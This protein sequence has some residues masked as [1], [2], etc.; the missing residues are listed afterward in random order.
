VCQDEGGLGDVCRFINDFVDSLEGLICGDGSIGDGG[1][2]SHDDLSFSVRKSLGNDG[3]GYLLFL[4]V[5]NGGEGFLFVR[6]SDFSIEVV[7]PGEV[8]FGRILLVQGSTIGGAGGASCGGEIPDI[9]RVLGGWLGD[10]GGLLGRLAIQFVGGRS[11]KLL[12]YFL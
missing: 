6:L 11:I 12:A 1:F 5:F 2:N 8:L 4:F 9:L 10:R 3:F 7:C